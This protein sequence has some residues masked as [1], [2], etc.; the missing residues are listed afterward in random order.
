MTPGAEPFKKDLVLAID[1]VPMGGA[2]I[3]STL[4]ICTHLGC[5][6]LLLPITWSDVLFIPTKLRQFYLA[7]AVRGHVHWMVW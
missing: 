7:R 4:L 1:W 6:R 2:G 5:L 3:L